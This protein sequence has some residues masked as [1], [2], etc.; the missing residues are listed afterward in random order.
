MYCMWLAK[1]TGRKKIAKNR[2]LGTISQLYRAISS[3]LRHMSTIG[4]KLVKEQYLLHMFP[5]YADLD[6]YGRGQ[7]RL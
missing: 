6:H 7:T 1:N 4:K 2:H 5:Q 3:Q